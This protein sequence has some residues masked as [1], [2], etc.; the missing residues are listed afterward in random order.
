MKIGLDH[1]PEQAR[2]DITKSAFPV[3]FASL[4]LLNCYYLFLPWLQ[5]LFS[6]SCLCPYLCFS[7]IPITRSHADSLSTFAA[8]LISAAAIYLV[9]RLF[10]RSLKLCRAHTLVALLV[11]LLI[12]ASLLEPIRNV[13]L[14]PLHEQLGNICFLTKDY[15]DA[16]EYYSLALH[17][18]FDRIDR[19]E[20]P[21]L[22][23]PCDYNYLWVHHFVRRQQFHKAL[24][25]C[26]WTYASSP[27]WS[28][29]LNQWVCEIRDKE[30]EV[31][32][33]IGFLEIAGDPILSGLH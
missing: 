13:L 28:N 15:A 27:D 10:C 6:I 23:A 4:I 18:S 19:L 5:K 12:F 31:G 32:Y 24:L 33:S 3:L 21:E 14:A 20:E 8:Y 22:D 9:G 29:Y 17:E 26:K 1:Y 7:M 11:S 2:Q 25:A 16:T 30:K